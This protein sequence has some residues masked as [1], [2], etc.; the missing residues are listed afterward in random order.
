MV[1]KSYSESKFGKMYLVPTPIGNIEDITY[2]A[3]TVLKEVDVIYAEDTR[4]AQSL[5]KKFNIKKK[6][7]SCHKYSEEKNK[8]AIFNEISSGKNVA[9]ISDRGTPLISD[10]GE[11]V[12]K[13]L[14]N[15]NIN[16]IS[17]PGPSAL[18]PAINISG[19]DNSR[20]LFYGFLN[21]KK[22]A[23][24]NELKTIAHLSFTIIFYEAPHRLIAT[25]NDLKTV[26]G[27]RNIAVCREISKIFEEVFR[28]SIEEAI[29][30]YS[31]PRGEIV[32]VV[33]GNKSTENID[34][35]EKVKD[36]VKKGYKVSNA[37]KEIAVIY[38][39]SKNDLYS[40]CKEKLL[41]N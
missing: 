10:P 31:D 11:V 12:V 40:E 1:Q 24:I 26:F 3:I 9:Y 21:S 5:L 20:F 23:R 8:E 25:L 4:V 19:L 34:Y 17:L 27:N 41:W 33:E 18:L 7:F 37:I 39:I 35:V 6:V 13:H 16:V 28:G 38:G 36:L 29:N 32:I 30:Y 2:R 15:N 22:N 14:I